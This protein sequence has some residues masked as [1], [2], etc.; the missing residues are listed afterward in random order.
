MEMQQGQTSA[1]L[2]EFREAVAEHPDD[3]VSHDYIGVILGEAGSL[4]EAVAEFEGAARLDSSLSDPHFHL[5]LAYEKLGN[6]E[7][8]KAY[9]Q[10]VRN[11]ADQ[12]ETAA[13]A[14]RRLAA[15]QPATSAAARAT[16]PSRTSTPAWSSGC[17]TRT[18]PRP[19]CGRWTRARPGSGGTTAAR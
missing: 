3:A 17:R 8:R 14:R 4:N 12:T 10:V 13:E 9:E 1:A 18:T 19:C 11:Y 16:S 5:G 6:A 15:L 2:A 7:A